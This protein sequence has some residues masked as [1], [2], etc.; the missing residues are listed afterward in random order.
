MTDEPMPVL[1]GSDNDENEDEKTQE[2]NE[3]EDGE[4]SE[5]VAKT[6]KKID[7]VSLEETE[8]KKLIAKFFGYIKKGNV[9]MVEGLATQF[10]ELLKSRHNY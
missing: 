6:V 1:E 2:E 3:K 8:E 5:E 9:D 10:P 7:E 4:E